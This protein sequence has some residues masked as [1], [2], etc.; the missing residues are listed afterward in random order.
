M[1]GDRLRGISL[2]GGKRQ[3]I[4]LRSSNQPA[5]LLLLNNHC[6]TA[7]RDDME[8][9]PITKQE[10]KYLQRNS[11]V[12]IRNIKKQTKKKASLVQQGEILRWLFS[13]AG[14]MCTC[15]A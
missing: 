6:Y 10:I 13:A 3:P 5:H 9:L 11:V 14:I 4:S 15:T 1:S 12:L 2:S 7:G 8:S